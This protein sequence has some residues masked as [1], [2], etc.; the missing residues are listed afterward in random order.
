MRIEHLELTDS[1][2]EVLKRK[3]DKEEYDVVYADNQTGGKGRRGN[4]WLSDKGAA[5]FSFIVKDRDYR[6]KTA[7]L[8]GYAVYSV[9]NE[10]LESDNL[11]FKWPNDI[12]YNGKKM[13]GILIEKSGEYLIIGIGVNVNNVD[14]G[15][16]AETASSLKLITGREYNIRDII[17]KIVEKTK[18][19][20]EKVS[21][22]WEYIID[23]LN[24]KHSLNNKLVEN[25][26]KEQYEVIKIN[27]DGSLKVKKAGD[28]NYTDIYSDD[29]KGIKIKK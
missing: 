8:T 27:Y 12:H 21:E 1:T 22:E 24:E 26:N 11:K 3:K 14:F 10:I 5:L 13:S 9:L 16:Y 28:K 29:I 15:M 4:K 20:L 7:L 19:K 23:Y 6:E 17:I 18:E 2:N 25:N